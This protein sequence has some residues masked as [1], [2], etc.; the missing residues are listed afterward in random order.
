V[1]SDSPE[2]TTNRLKALLYQ[3]RALAKSLI[4]N[5]LPRYV[6]RAL[7]WVGLLYLPEDILA[8]LAHRG[9]EVTLIASPEDA[10][11]FTARGG[12][13]ALDRLQSTSRPPRLVVSPTGDHSAHHPAILAEIRTAALPVA[14]YASERSA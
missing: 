10:E 5:H 7:S 9:T 12:R 6:L 1:A 14:A 2:S 4:H 13:A 3:P 8:T 11:Q